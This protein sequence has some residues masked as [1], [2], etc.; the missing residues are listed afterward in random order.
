MAH[1]AAG[2]EQRRGGHPGAG[3]RPGGLRLCLSAASLSPPPWRAGPSALPGSTGAR[4]PRAGVPAAPGGLPSP[5]PRQ[6]RA[7]GWR[8]HGALSGLAAQRPWYQEV[9]GALAP[10]HG[11]LRA[12]LPGSPEARTRSEARGAQAADG[13]AERGICVLS[14]FAD[15][16][17]RCLHR[18]AAP[19]SHGR[20]PPR[21]QTTVNIWS[22][23]VPSAPYGAALFPLQEVGGHPSSHGHGQNRPPAVERSLGAP[24]VTWAASLRAR[25]TLCDAEAG[26]S[27][28]WGSGDHTGPGRRLVPHRTRA[29]VCARARVKSQNRKAQTHTSREPETGRLAERIRGNLQAPP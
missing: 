2:G 3:V 20:G 25:V 29:S 23:P 1:V 13:G 15:R 10:S 6:V 22:A 21:A 5:T 7:A 24:G 14:V 17:S 19:A 27:R 12:G 9:S 4:N 18:D 11:P 26:G 28:D 8:G 16:L